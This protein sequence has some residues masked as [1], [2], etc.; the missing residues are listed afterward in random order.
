MGFLGGLLSKLAIF[1]LTR[2][3]YERS[4][5][6]KQRLNSLEKSVALIRYAN[7]IRSERNDP[8]AARRR[9]REGE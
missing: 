8:D 4:G 6:N 1:F 9:L 5:A 3:H 7:E 2:A